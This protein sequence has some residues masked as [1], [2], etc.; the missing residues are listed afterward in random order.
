MSFTSATIPY[1]YFRGGLQSWDSET[2]Q[3]LDALECGEQ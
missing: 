1:G 2:A 3:Y